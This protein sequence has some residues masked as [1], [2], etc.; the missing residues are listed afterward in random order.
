MEETIRQDG[1]LE[2]LEARTDSYL[3]E[4]PDEI[5]REYLQNLK[6]RIKAQKN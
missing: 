1:K 4:N 3:A 6:G 5:F 2:Q